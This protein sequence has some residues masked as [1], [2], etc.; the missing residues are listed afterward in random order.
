MLYTRRC[1]LFTQFDS[2]FWG[3][4][5]TDFFLVVTAAL[6]SVLFLLPSSAKKSPSSFFRWPQEEKR[7]MLL[8]WREK[9]SKR[10][11]SDAF[12]LSALSS[13]LSILDPVSVQ[14]PVER[15]LSFRCKWWSLSASLFSFSFHLADW[16]KSN[17]SSYI[18]KHSL[19]SGRKYEIRALALTRCNNF[20]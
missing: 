14:F 5:T 20:N 8:R 1:H 13:F 17:S 18:H 15:L 6:F 19:R 12:S 3:W 16:S 2:L 11:W 4:S 9:E 10:N 7:E